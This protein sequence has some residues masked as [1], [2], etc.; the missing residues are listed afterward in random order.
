MLCPAVDNRIIM[1]AYV[2]TSEDFA[3]WLDRKREEANLSKIELARRAGISRQA[4]SDYIGRKRT[5]PEEWVLR[6]LAPVLQ[7]SEHEIFVAAG[8]LS[9]MPDEDFEIEQITQELNRL[10]PEQK[11]VVQ[12]LIRI[13][14]AQTS[15]ESETQ[16]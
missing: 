8:Y 9:P 16:T 12:N 11:R 5:R 3:S 4:I 7:V 6:R 14:A 2:D 15:G 13:L 10:R 1:S